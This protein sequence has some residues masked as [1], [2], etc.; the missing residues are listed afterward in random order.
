[1]RVRNPDE[2]VACGAALVAA[3]FARGDAQRGRGRITVSTKV[4][5]R[6]ARVTVQRRTSHALGTLTCRR[7]NGRISLENEPIIPE[8]ADLPAV[9]KKKF[10]LAPRQNSLQVPVL[11]LD[12]HNQV[13]EE[14]GNYRF[15][16]FGLSDKSRE[17]LVQF[18]YDASG[19]PAVS[20]YDVETGREFP[21]RRDKFVPPD[22]SQPSGGEATVVLAVD[23][24][25]MML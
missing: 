11:Q 23:C 12:R 7:D 21:S 16:D 6:I 5:G 14:L 1:M 9:V 19:L 8:N 18:S 10:Q 20:V 17:V 4:G 2:A 3:G 24:S 13:Q 15:D 22:L 25:Y